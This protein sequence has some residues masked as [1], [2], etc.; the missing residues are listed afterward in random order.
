MLARRRAILQSGLVPA[1]IR[2][3]HLRAWLIIVLAVILGGSTG[4]VLIERWSPMDAAYMT[5]ITLTTVGF[6]E[7]HDLDTAGRLW[8]MG[9]SVAGVAIIFGSIG[10]VA[11]AVIAEAASGKREA[12]TMRERI[13]QLSDHFI[14]CG[15]GRVGATVARELVNAGQAIVVVEANPTA[16]SQAAAAGFLVV[17]GDATRDAIL[18]AAGIERARGLVTAIDSDANNV[19]VTLSARGLNE[20]LV[21]VAR[22]NE[23]GSEAKLHQAGADRAVSPYTRAGRQLAVLATRPNVADFIDFALSTGELSFSIEELRIETTSPL[24]GR[25]VDELRTEGIHV[26]AIVRAERDYE[27]S[28][29]RDRRLDPGTVVIAAGNASALHRLGAPDTSTDGGSS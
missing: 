24:A 22:A 29:E 7:V 16:A 23:V 2:A 19:F 13:G 5:V 9:L 20:K 6:R 17:E 1:V 21:I 25:T 14:V 18:V 4:Y 26:L 28:P 11:E 10:I 8:T 27:A 3:S 12:R 15:F